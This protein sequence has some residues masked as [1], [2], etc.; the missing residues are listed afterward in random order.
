MT[1]EN[2]LRSF[3]ADELHGD[4]REKLTDEYPLIE[5]GVVDSMGILSVVSFIE[6]EFGVEIE[7]EEL[8]SENFGTI[9]GMTRLI[10]SK[11]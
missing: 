5:R 7:D 4:G 3:I 10:E 1:T 6:S 2:R 8:V 11:R 9:A